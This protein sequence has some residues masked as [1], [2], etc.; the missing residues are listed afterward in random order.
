MQLR[1]LKYFCVLCEELHFGRAASRLAITQP[2]L[3][4][5]I[6]SLEDDLGVKLLV[7]NSKLVQLTPAGAAFL[8]EANHILDSVAQARS[9]V[10]AVDHGIRGRVEIGTAGSLLYREVPEIIAR[11]KREMPGVQVVL[12]EVP[13]AEHLQALLGGQLHAAFLNGPSV[14]PQLK[15]LALREDELA[16]CL[17]VAHRLARRRSIRLQE[18]A[19]EDFV[20]FSRATSPVHHDSVISS[21]SRAGIHPQISHRARSWLTIVSMVATH[22]G[23]ALVPRSLER[24][25]LAGVRFVALAGESTPAPGLLVW[26]P[27]SVSPPLQRF[28]EVAA[29]VARGGT[30]RRQGAGRK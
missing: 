26:N 29:D 24:S 27:K 20:M 21:F 23:V 4:A 3:S 11:F 15:S 9:V 10:R 5:A 17:P 30:T 6:K 1:F 16:A 12:H 25:G 28:L 18:L 19:E 8:E 22:G 7:R 13:S 14:H 2:P